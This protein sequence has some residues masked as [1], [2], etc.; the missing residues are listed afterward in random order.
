MRR[1]SWCSDRP[2]GSPPGYRESSAR[3]R[4]ASLLTPFPIVLVGP[5]GGED[6]VGGS[7][8]RIRELRSH[9]AERRAP[10]KPIDLPGCSLTDGCPHPSLHDLVGVVGGIA[11]L[12]RTPRPPTPACAQTTVIL[13]FRVEFVTVVPLTP[14]ARASP[15]R[16]TP[17]AKM[18]SRKIIIPSRTPP[19]PTL[20]A[21]FVLWSRRSAHRA[22]RR[23]HASC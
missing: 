13:Q 10:A 18:R 2:L 17:Q 19:T 9:A 22:S 23:H 1:T 14:P 5:Q 6:H 4:Q 12:V 15:T 8:I 21:E 7:R 16:T 20:S 3:V 11:D